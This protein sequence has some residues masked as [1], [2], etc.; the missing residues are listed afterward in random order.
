MSEPDAIAA[1]LTAIETSITHV[2]HDYEGLHQ[3]VLALQTDVRLLQ[4]G[5]QKLTSQL[6]RLAQDPEVRDPE[7]ERPPHY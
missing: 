6:E 1:R 5:L 2:Q 4:L 3:A 7:L